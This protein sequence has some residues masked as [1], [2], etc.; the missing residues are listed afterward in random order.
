MER[1]TLG[2]AFGRCQTPAGRPIGQMETLGFR[3]TETLF[4]TGRSGMHRISAG[5]WRDDKTSA[6]RDYDF[7][8]LIGGTIPLAR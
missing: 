5:P 7:G 4:P 2:G 1:G 3:L 6:F 8:R